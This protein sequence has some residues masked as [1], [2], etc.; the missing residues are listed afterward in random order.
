[1]EFFFAMD[2][3]LLNGEKQYFEIENKAI[4]G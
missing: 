4:Q 2:L 1:M 3:C